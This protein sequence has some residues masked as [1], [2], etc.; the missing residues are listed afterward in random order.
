MLVTA[1][2]SSRAARARR[3]PV[4]PGGTR[5]PGQ[6][7]TPGRQKVLG[8]ANYTTNSLRCPWDMSPSAQEPSTAVLPKT[9]T[10]GY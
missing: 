3:R 9:V 1:R 5:K 6:S 4:A 10:A 8:H 7:P 2:A